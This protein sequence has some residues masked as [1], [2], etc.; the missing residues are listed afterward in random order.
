MVLQEYREVPKQNLISND[1]I[2]SKK[3]SA[4][5]DKMGGSLGTISPKSLRGSKQHKRVCR[6][7]I[8]VK[9]QQ[10]APL[11]AWEGTVDTKATLTVKKQT[12]TVLK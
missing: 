5:N 2:L 12:K 8:D 9:M 3:G 4:F 1:K 10:S 11:L 7:K 6:D